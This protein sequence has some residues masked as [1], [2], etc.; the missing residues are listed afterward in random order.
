MTAVGDCCS[1]SWYVLHDL[2]INSLIGKKFLEMT[3]ASEEEELTIGEYN[4]E[5]IDQICQKCD[6]YKLILQDDKPFYFYLPI[7][8]RLL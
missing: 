8:P 7:I 1:N 2:P 6:L 5:E 3:M 4:K